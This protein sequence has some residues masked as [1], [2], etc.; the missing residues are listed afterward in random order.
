MRNGTNPRL[1]TANE[2]SQIVLILVIKAPPTCDSGMTWLASSWMGNATPSSEEKEL[3][4]DKV[5]DVRMIERA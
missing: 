3:M 4:G 2:S 1:W 5:P